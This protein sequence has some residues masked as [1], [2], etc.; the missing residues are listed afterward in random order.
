MLHIYLCVS[1]KYNE[2]E[3][4]VPDLASLQN[5]TQQVI[6]REELLNYE[7]WALQRMGWI[8]CGE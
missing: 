3:T 8:L 6:P 2:N 1:A 4:L 7:I 5:I